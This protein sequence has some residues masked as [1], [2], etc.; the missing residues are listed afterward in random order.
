M[1]T[2]L[3]I[4][5]FFLLV[6]QICFAQW[7]H[8]N[9]G[10]SVNLNSIHLENVNTGWVVGDSGTIFQTTK[11]GQEWIPQTSG[12]INHLNEVWFAD[13]NTG[14]VVGDSGKILKTITGGQEWIEQTSGTNIHLNSVCFTDVNEGWVVGEGI[15]LHTNNG[16]TV[17][18]KQSNDTLQPNLNSICFVDSITVWAVG[19]SQILKTIDGGTNWANPTQAEFGL[20]L[21]SVYFADSNNG[22][23]TSPG[24]G[25]TYVG[26]GLYY[27]TN[28]GADWNF[29]YTTL[30]SSIYFADVN[31]VWAVGHSCI[32]H[33]ENMIKSIDGGVNW[34]SQ[35]NIT[36]EWLN[37]VYFTDLN[38]GWVVGD[39]GTILHTTNGG[40][41]F[42]E[43][44]QID[45]V[46]TEFLLSQNFPN[47]FNPNTKIKY[48]VPQASNVVVKVYDV[49]G[50]EIETLVS[51]EKSVGTYE[52]TWNAANLASGV[53]FYR[54]Q[55]G[56]YVQTRKMILL[57]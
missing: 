17:W 32:V 20:D 38:N 46:P 39:N 19:Y 14:W 8:Q 54:L 44:E 47:P 15:I 3:R 11:G 4:L 53:Y 24:G 48:S 49:L 29:L 7:Y 26:G 51:E 12:T 57:K 1:K 55:A 9:S 31:N 21:S 22:W 50:T 42:V 33:S 56:D 34:I 45:K 52:L 2:F 30:L 25:D 16:G 10:T 37:S 5:F 41:S 28:G 18:V 36:S 27:T 6:T 40:V 35:P 43:E 23:I 13:L